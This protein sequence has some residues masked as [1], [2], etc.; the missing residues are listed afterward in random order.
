MSPTCFLHR[1]RPESW[2]TPNFRVKDGFV[3]V[4]T[5]PGLGVDFDPGYIAQLRK[6]EA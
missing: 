3:A 2:Y 4:P 6:V 5:G 1:C